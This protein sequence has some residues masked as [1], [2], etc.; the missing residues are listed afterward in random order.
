MRVGTFGI[1]ACMAA[2][3][4]GVAAAEPWDPCGEVAAWPGREWRLTEA[5]ALGWDAAKLTDAKTKFEM[6]QSASVVI[7]HKGRLIAA[8]GDDAERFTAQS[9]RKGLL[10]S[11]V[12]IL[13]DDGKLSLDATLA[14]LGIDDSE[15]PLTEA[16]K[17]ASLRDLLHSRSGIF[18][19]ALY[20]VG[21]W[22]RMRAELAQEKSETGGYAPGDYWIY[23][24]W[25]FNALGTIVEDAAGEP[26]GVFFE[27]KIAK[28]IAMQDFRP[29][30]VEY[31]TKDHPA[32]QRF[33]N[34]SDHR[35]YMFNIST[36][37]L[38]RYG[39]LYLGCGKW[40][41]RE[42]VSKDWVLASLDGI[43]TRRG[44][45]PDEQ[46]TGFGDYGYL[47]QIDRPGARR[48]PE[49]K[50]REPAY[51][52]TGNRGHVLAVFPYL[53]LVIAHQVGT[54]GGVS[55]EAQKKRAIEGSPEVTD[56]EMTDLFKA[57]IAAHPDGATAL[58]GQ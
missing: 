37:D 6:L 15:P 23:N 14:D 33:N 47:W 45:G 26:I 36:R 52:A 20:E 40:K 12:G 25:D 27:E 8:W 4:S 1:V 9:V 58:D 50:T 34:V 17:Q 44:R 18:H 32:E 2:F 54:R 19:S 24:N 7:V 49:L 13:V 5:T 21:G 30:D 3:M 38:A 10:N 51:F 41:S 43:D 28:P 39:V 11:L 31:T 22:K 16:E 29:E 48:Y 57:I 53:D 46:R 55:M 35:A 56:E 42:I